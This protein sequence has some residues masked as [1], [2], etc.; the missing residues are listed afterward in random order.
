MLPPEQRNIQGGKVVIGR[1]A[2]LGQY[3]IIMPRVTIGEGAIVGPLSL[4]VSS[5]KPWTVVMGVPAKVIGT[6]EPVKL[7]NP[8]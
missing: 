3:S 8:D 6:R 4:V 5:V 2:F 7:P 1:D